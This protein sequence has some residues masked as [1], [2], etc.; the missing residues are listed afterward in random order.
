MRYFNRNLQ[1]F[2]PN[3]ILLVI[4]PKPTGGGLT[5]VPKTVRDRCASR[6]RRARRNRGCAQ[7]KV[8]IANTGK[9]P[10]AYPGM[11]LY[12]YFCKQLMRGERLGKIEAVIAELD[13]V[14][15]S[16]GSVIGEDD[17]NTAVR[18]REKGIRL[19][20]ITDRHLNFVKH[21]LEALGE[22]TV[23]A[24]FDLTGAYL[25]DADE[26]APWN[27]RT[28]SPDHAKKFFAYTYGAAFRVSL[29]TAHSPF[30][31]KGDPRLWDKTTPYFRDGKPLFKHGDDYRY[32]DEFSRE[33]IQDIIQMGV[34]KTPISKLADFR[35]LFGDCCL[36]I[37][38]GSDATFNGD[39]QPAGADRP[40]GVRD[41]AAHFGFPLAKTVLVSGSA[42][43]ASLAGVL[44]SA[45]APEGSELAAAPKVKGIQGPGVLTRALRKYI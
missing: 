11:F 33:M 30:Y 20:L 6:Q 13:S 4:L 40:S 7:K 27:V 12:I 3:R 1:I 29:C 34:A 5:E 2:N 24:V 39:I 31:S 9:I 18:L 43:D 26:K 15:L 41:A 17:L 38:E 36:T 10:V 19:I 42:K 37:E 25:Y 14:L 44:S 22:G 32:R 23:S 21:S 16:G 45:F 28:I 35:R 8:E